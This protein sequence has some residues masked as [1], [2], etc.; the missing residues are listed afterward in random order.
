MSLAIR[1]LAFDGFRGY[2]HLELCGLGGLNVLVGPNAVGKTNI[3]EGIELLTS[4]ESFRR[5][6]WGETVSWGRDEAALRAVF[7]D[8]KREVEHR[9]T[10]RGN[11][12]SYQV[13]GKRK[14]AS[15]VRANCPSVLFIPDDLQLVKASSAKRRAALDSLGRR[16]SGGY[17]KLAEE[18]RRA[19]AQ[20]NLLVKEGIHQGPLFESWD[21]ALAVSGGRLA[22]ARMRLFARLAEKMG[23]AYGQIVPGETLAA[24]YLPSWRRF[25]AEGRQLEAPLERAAAP[26][27][28]LTGDI[29][30]AE[31]SGER[32]ARLSRRLAAS[33]LRRKTTLAGPHKDEVAFFI[34]GKNARSFASQGQQRSIVLAWKLAEVAVVSE[35]A[36][37]RPV[38]L[39]DD[40]MSELDA[41]RR[42]AVAEFFEASAQAFVTTTNLGYFS[43]PA[44]ARAD[45]IELPIPGTREAGGGA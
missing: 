8:G 1:D 25:D 7:A 39:L 38:L 43:A 21:E 40:V 24:A 20:R 37:L 18:Y 14:T 34:D 35:I 26:T 31:E 9:L 32:I 36:G 4:A 11:E 12:R 23:A 29:P 16:L 5:P 2:S 42:D 44:L 41:A 17:A 45:V 22:S 6:A 19:L 30:S 10:I 33:E 28:A 3:V 13:N 15:A 27:C